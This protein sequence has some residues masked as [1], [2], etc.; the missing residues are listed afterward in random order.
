MGQDRMGTCVIYYNRKIGLRAS[1]KR[2]FFHARF[3]DRRRLQAGVFISSEKEVA[4]GNP[5]LPR[6][7]D[8]LHIRH[9]V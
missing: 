9:H 7:I 1:R 4:N 8:H 2:G 6:R 5:D 3:A